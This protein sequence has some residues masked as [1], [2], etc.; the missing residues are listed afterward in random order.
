MRAQ[1]FRKLVTLVVLL[2]AIR[3]LGL[4]ATPRAAALTAGCA[5]YTNAHPNLEN[6]GDTPTCDPQGS[7]CFECMYPN[8][9]GP[10]YILCSE[11]PETW[12]QPDCSQRIFNLEDIPPSY[13]GPDEVPPVDPL[14]PDVGSPDDSGSPPSQDP[15]NQLPPP[16][17]GGG[18]PPPSVI[19]S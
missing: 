19:S 11:Y 15:D 7:G 8:P 18:D 2:A 1:T 3:G 9:S 10:G 16:D 13:M 4:L 5:G 6:T 17:D 14:P 12:M